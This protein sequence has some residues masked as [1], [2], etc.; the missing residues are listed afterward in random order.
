[1]QIPR[2]SC[3]KLLRP[4]PRDFSLEFPIGSHFRRRH[5]HDDSP[6][7]LR[8]MKSGQSASIFLCLSHAAQGVG[9]A[10]LRAAFRRG[11]HDEERGERKSPRRRKRVNRPHSTPVLRLGDLMA[12]G[13][14]ILL[15]KRPPRYTELASGRQV[16]FRRLG[17][18]LATVANRF[19]ICAQ[20]IGWANTSTCIDFAAVA[21]IVKSTYLSRPR[22]PTAGTKLSAIRTK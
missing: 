18:N 17:P 20:R 3:A 12:T 1:M 22:P 14:S 11:E 19:A 10:S 7:E 4:C 16:F 13:Q 15:C 9:A 2:G 6:V 8:D 5:R 21:K